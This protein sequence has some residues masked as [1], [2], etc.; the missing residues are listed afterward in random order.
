MKVALPSS[1]LS[2]SPILVASLFDFNI[3]VPLKEA[4]LRTAGPMLSLRLLLG[5]NTELPVSGQFEPPI[6]F[7]LPLVRSSSLDALLSGVFGPSQSTNKENVI[8]NR[9][10]SCLYFE[11]G[12]RSLGGEGCWVKDFSQSEICCECSH[13]T[14]FMA[15]VKSSYQTLE[16]SNYSAL[17]A[18][19]QFSL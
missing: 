15:F 14:D 8:A 6:E 1:I 17:F 12:T 10:L 16:E 4:A 11:T 2:A 7:C 18:V 19:T 3:Y 13:L 5:P 9:E